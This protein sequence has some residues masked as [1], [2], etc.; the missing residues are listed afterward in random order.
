[1]LARP[2]HGCKSSGQ[3]H[4]ERNAIGQLG[5]LFICNPKDLG[6]GAGQRTFQGR[7]CRDPVWRQLRAS[8]P[9]DC[10]QHHH[11]RLRLQ[12]IHLRIPHQCHMHLARRNQSE[13]CDAHRHSRPGRR[14]RDQIFLRPARNLRRGSKPWAGARR[15]SDHR[16]WKQL[17]QHLADHQDW[18][19]FLR[20][21]HDMGSDLALLC[22]LL[23]PGWHRGA[24]CR[25]H[26]RGHLEQ[27]CNTQKLRRGSAQRHKHLAKPSALRGP[28]RCLSDRSQLWSRQLGREPGTASGTPG[29]GGPG[30]PGCP[31]HSLSRLCISVRFGD[32][33]QNPRRDP[34]PAGKCRRHRRLTDRIG[35]LA[36]LLHPLETVRQ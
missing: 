22:H 27:C 30:A 3:G 24:S 14:R 7:I 21:T 35:V 26:H 11:R 34:G 1:M 13:S 5:L 18:R 12:R 17:W 33:M 28:E 8:G 9:R 25:V 23:C 32:H 2:V 29:P 16:V 36:L 10:T 15:E 6:H 19:H 4:R 31:Q 20:S